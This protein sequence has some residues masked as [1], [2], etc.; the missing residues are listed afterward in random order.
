MM[1]SVVEGLQGVKVYQDDVLVCAPTEGEHDH[2][3]YALLQR[4]LEKNVKINADKSVFKKNE[5]EY[6][7]YIVSETGYRPDPKRFVTSNFF[8]R[9]EVCSRLFAVFL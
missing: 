2:F 5:L 3:L 1:N 7:G 8:R 6:L 9:V 4:F